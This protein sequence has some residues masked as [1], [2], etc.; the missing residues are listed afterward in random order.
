M[1][2]KLVFIFFLSFASS[3]LGQFSNLPG[4]PFIKNFPQKILKNLFLLK[5][6]Y[7]PRAVLKALILRNYSFGQMQ[8][9]TEIQ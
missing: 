2:R 3:I 4:T 5:T 9:D 6:Y 1:F 8:N 7:L